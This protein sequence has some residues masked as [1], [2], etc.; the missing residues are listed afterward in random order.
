MLGRQQIRNYYDRLG[1]T[2]DTQR[3]YEDPAIKKLLAHGRFDTAKSVFELGYGTGRFADELLSNHLP[4]PAT[5]RGCDLSPVMIRLAEEKIS[6][7]GNR[8]HV[9]LTDGSLRFD[10]PDASVDRFVANYVLDLLPRDDIETTLSEAHRML[11]PGGYLCL[12]S[13]SYSPKPFSRLLIA[14][15]KRVHRL[16]PGLVGGCR[17]LHLKEFV[18]PDSWEVLHHEMVVAFGLPSE[19]VVARKLR[20]L[21][22]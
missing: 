10:A 14:A 2:L 20:H 22:L 18:S 19:I 9:H 12:V 21:T 11:E 17:P 5:Y 4:R 13:L 8:A 7:F 6:C 16:R 15:W 1:A 3:F